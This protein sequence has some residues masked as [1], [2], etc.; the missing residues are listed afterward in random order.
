[1]MKALDKWFVGMERLKKGGEYRE[2]NVVWSF[3]WREM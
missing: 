2:L 1:M 3:C